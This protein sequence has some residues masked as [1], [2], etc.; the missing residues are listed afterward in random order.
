MAPGPGTGLR[1]E[2]LGVARPLDPDVANACLRIAQEAAGNAV[3]H[4]NAS[5]IV[6]TAEFLED[7]ILMRV[8]DNGKGFDVDCEREVA[9]W[10]GFGLRNM[11]KRAE[12]INGELT[13]ES[14]PTGTAVTLKISA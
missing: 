5:D 2:V 3:K 13:L 14:G 1:F 11:R 8:E 9:G 6:V 10:S 12:E 4:A 7:G